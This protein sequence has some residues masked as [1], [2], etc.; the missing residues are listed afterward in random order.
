ML[1]NHHD[2]CKGGKLL[3]RVLLDFLLISAEQKLD[4][5]KIV[6]WNFNVRKHGIWCIIFLFFFTCKQSKTFA[7]F[8]SIPFNLNKFAQ[9][10]EHQN[11]LFKIHHY[12]LIKFKVTWDKLK[13]IQMVKAG[14][15]IFIFHICIYISIYIY[16]QHV[17]Y[18][19]IMP[20]LYN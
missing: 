16:Y 19:F 9:D 12:P 7:V 17:F 14:V 6:H 10:N 8:N 4:D 20:N 18:T 11:V 3:K 5:T 2:F 13:N 1:N 15:L